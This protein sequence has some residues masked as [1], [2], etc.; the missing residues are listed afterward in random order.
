MN[1]DK[2]STSVH[3]IN[4]DNQLRC[5]FM[6]HQ[7]R[8]AVVDEIDSRHN[9]LQNEM[10]INRQQ[11]QDQM[12]EKNYHQQINQQSNSGSTNN[13][14]NET[15]KFA[16]AHQPLLQHTNDEIS[17]S[18][19]TIN[20]NGKLDESS[21]INNNNR[22][23]DSNNYERYDFAIPLPFSDYK[24][25]PRRSELSSFMHN[26]LSKTLDTFSKLSSLLKED[27]DERSDD[28]LFFR[29]SNHHQQQQ[30]QNNFNVQE[31]QQKFPPPSLPAIEAKNPKSR[32]API[33]EL[34]YDSE[35]KFKSK[36]YLLERIF[37]GGLESDSLR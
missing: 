33:T 16:I 25:P 9:D 7:S 24:A 34:E 20:T 6:P 32:L 23:V 26:P 37:L 22:N 27:L 19:C 29:Q 17:S 14:P 13:S 10:Q 1:E 36:L 11:Q 28:N 12:N 2:N 15:K 4:G 3:F 35:L 18:F 21:V 5:E 30:Q 8:Q 31:T